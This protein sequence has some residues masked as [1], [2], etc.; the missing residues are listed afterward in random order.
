[1]INFD[2]FRNRHPL[3]SRIGDDSLVRSGEESEATKYQ[4]VSLVKQYLRECFTIEAGA[5]G[6]AIDYW[7][8]T[9][10]VLLTCFSRLQTSDTQT[11]DIVIFKTKDRTDYAGFGHIGIATGFTTST[12]V[13]V[14]EQ[15]G[16]TGGGTGTGPDAIRTRYI[17]RSRIAGLLRPIPVVNPVR[18]Y[19]PDVSGH[20]EMLTTK[21]PTS[22]WNLNGT[23]MDINS[24]RPAAV[25]NVG[26]PFTV[27]GY[28]HHINGHTYAMTLEDFN[29]AQNGDYSTNNGINVLDLKDK[30]VV[31]YTPP[32]PPAP[33]IAYLPPEKYELVTAVPYYKDDAE[34]GNIGYLDALHSQNPRGKKQPGVYFVYGD[35]TNGMLNISQDNMKPGVWINP[36]DN[37]IAEEPTVPVDIVVPTVEPVDPPLPTPTHGSA[38]WQVGR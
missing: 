34:L 8:G 37:V 1:M 13:E 15:N 38:D 33:P 10:P 16:S 17:D 7:T 31:V 19:E 26:T 25:L 4:C 23:T 22:W 5:W 3:G 30:P 35:K 18:F 29:R 20:R 11:G 24:F 2:D 12:S 6:N 14:L 9:N 32:P 28:A 27:G 36:K 21:Q